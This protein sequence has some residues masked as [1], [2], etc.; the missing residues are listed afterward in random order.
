MCIDRLYTTFINVIVVD[1]YCLRILLGYM[2]IALRKYW[3]LILLLILVLVFVYTKNFRSLKENKQLI[4]DTVQVHQYFK[5]ANYYLYD[6]PTPKLSVEK[7]YQQVIKAKNLS[8]SSSYPYGEGE[9]NLM[10][11]NIYK[12]KNKKQD[13]ISS[14]LAAIK[15]FKRTQLNEKLGDGYAQLGWFYGTDA[16][17]IDQRI[18][19]HDAAQKY[20]G[21]CNSKSKRAAMLLDLADCYMLKNDFLK[22]EH[23]LHNV[24]AIFKSIGRKDVQGVYN[25]LNLTSINLGK[26]DSAVSYGMKAA[27]VAAEVHD[28]SLQLC[29]I[30]NR[31]G[32]AYHCKGQFVESGQYF[33]K[34]LKV[35]EKFNDFNSIFQVVRN[36]ANNSNI[37][38][39]YQKTI[40]TVE[41]FEDHYP[42]QIGNFDR[43]LF[44]Q[45]LL[46]A[47]YGIG[48][49]LKARRCFERILKAARASDQPLIVDG[50]SV[51]IKYNLH[52]GLYTDAE[53]LIDEA[54]LKYR[55]LNLPEAYLN[56]YSQ[57]VELHLKRGRYR[58]AIE[59][60]ADFKEVSDSIFRD[61]R[62]KQVK[63]LESQYLDEMNLR[64]KLQQQ[65][66]KL[67]L[68]KNRLQQFQL[69]QTRRQT[70]S[71]YIGLALLVVLLIV[72]YCAFVLKKRNNEIL[73]KQK[74]EIDQ[75][76]SSLELLINAQVK[77]ISEKEWLVREVN[78]R[79]KNNLQIIISLLNFQSNYL[80]DASASA[81]IKD[82]QNRIRAISMIHQQLYQS[83]NIKNVDIEV[84]IKELIAYL[85]K[86]LDFEKNVHFEL[87]VYSV[88]LEIA[89]VVSIGLLLNEAITNAMKY[90]FEGSDKAKINIELAL[91]KDGELLLIIS[92][93]GRGLPS[94][95]DSENVTTLGFTLIK[96]M[97]EQLDGQLEVVNEQGLKISVKFKPEIVI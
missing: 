75:Q 49:V 58:K 97:V 77:L 12:A 22:S 14:T 3:A 44:D 85:K 86:A 73:K 90:A 10:L 53:K 70:N 48:D 84:Y 36:I 19:N 54:K 47:Y 59:E 93:N 30:Y 37:L 26:C 46:I 94:N 6:A 21:M 83:E 80:K 95:F 76:N 56:I 61:S 78:H 4:N 20:Y 68:T 57:K 52:K 60:Y 32:L 66:T 42:E 7:A 50:Y 51:L 29:S 34:S 67:L 45:H 39:K 89:Q 63:N 23:I 82:S 96:T 25:L 92:D 87:K 81:A 79:V 65:N 9:S 2:I 69:E 43:D 74:T 35:A 11:S 5:K 18:V 8:I 27:S 28:E 40:T 31:I 41:N 13:A 33:D 64:N 62:E 91:L 71:L 16:S 1:L 17:E 55:R 24:L 15:I 38:G 72:S 88:K